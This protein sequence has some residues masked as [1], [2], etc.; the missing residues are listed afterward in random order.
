MSTRSPINQRVALWFTIFILGT[1]QGG[2]MQRIE[3]YARET[4]GERDKTLRIRKLKRN[5]G[6]VH[7]QKELHEI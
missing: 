3:I 1:S 2:N 5:R 4:R 6:C 7:E